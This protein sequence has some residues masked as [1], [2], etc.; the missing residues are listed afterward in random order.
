MNAFAWGQ[1]AAWVA[2]AM[3]GIWLVVDLLRTNH[4]YSEDVLMSSREGEIEATA[5]RH[6]I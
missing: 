3:L 2:S 1:A 4:R 5:E 6:E